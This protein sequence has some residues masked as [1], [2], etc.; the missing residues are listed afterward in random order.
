MNAHIKPLERIYLS[1]LLILFLLIVFTPYIIGSGISLF[2]EEL[3]EVTAIVF[4]FSV[5]CVVLLLYRKEVAKN[6]RELDRF[7]QDKNNLEQ[8]LVEAFKYIGTVNIQVREIKAAFSDIDKFPETKKDFRYILQFLADRTLSMVNAEWVLLRIINTQNLDTLRE[9]CQA[10]GKAVILKHKIG[11]R[12]LL[13]NVTPE[14]FTIVESGQ[15][16]F[17]IRTLCIMPKATISQEQKIF[18]KA[19]VNQ[20]EMLFVIFTSLYYKDARLRFT[21]QSARLTENGLV[22]T[23]HLNEKGLSRTGDIVTRETGLWHTESLS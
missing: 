10:R 18:V 14:G 4:L 20:L 5:G 16:N 12:E 21:D 13:S 9:Y 17:H 3:V 7:K 22:R 11:N 19:M 1:A 15:E 6:L 23:R 2:E 8:Q